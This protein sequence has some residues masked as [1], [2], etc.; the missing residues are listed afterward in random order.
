MVQLGA[1]ALFFLGTAALG[2]FATFLLYVNITRKKVTHKKAAHIAS[3]IKQGAMTFLRKE[4][5]ILA[6][7]ITI[8]FIAL[9]IFSN[10]EPSR[11]WTRL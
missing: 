9:T 4:Y 2:L 8:A 7:V 5:S 6:I 3:L 1:Y 10:V 11:L